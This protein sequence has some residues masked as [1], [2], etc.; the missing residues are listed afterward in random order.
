VVLGRV[1]LLVQV[2]GPERVGMDAVGFGQGLVGSL[3]SRNAH[4]R[5]PGG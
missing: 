4:R 3:P 1:G 2:V 5:A